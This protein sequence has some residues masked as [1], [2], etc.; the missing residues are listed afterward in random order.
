MHHLRL[1]KLKFKQMAEQIALIIKYFK[2]SISE[3]ENPV[4]FN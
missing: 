1:T 2:N 3:L 4:Y